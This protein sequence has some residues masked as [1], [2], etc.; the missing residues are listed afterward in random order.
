MPKFRCHLPKKEGDEKEAKKT[1][2]GWDATFV[3]DGPTAPKGMVCKVVAPKVQPQPKAAGSELPKA[4]TAPAAEAVKEQP[5]AASDAVPQEAETEEVIEVPA[6]RPADFPSPAG[7]QSVSNPS[8]GAAEFMILATVTAVAGAMVSSTFSNPADAKGKKGQKGKQSS[9]QDQRSRLDQQR[10]EREEKE[11]KDCGASTEAVKADAQRDEQKFSAVLAS[12]N[13]LIQRL[14]GM[15]EDD[16]SELDLHIRKLAARV[17]RLEAR[18]QAS[19]KRDSEPRT[20]RRRQPKPDPH[21]K[22]DAAKAPRPRRT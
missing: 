11:R 18:Q 4:V 20:A 22:P 1:K 7:A 16:V 3:F 8:G 9:K 21:A 13:G 19:S 10:Q 6:G 15:A 2:D 12:V 17:A 5:K 14:D